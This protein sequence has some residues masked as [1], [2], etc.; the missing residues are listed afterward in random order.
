MS[1]KP[2]RC[3][4][5]PHYS[6]LYLTIAAVGIFQAAS[7][8]DYSSQ[9]RVQR[10]LAAA[11]PRDTRCCICPLEEPAFEWWG[12]WSLRRPPALGDIGVGTPNG[13]Q[14]PTSSRPTAALG[15][16]RTSRAS[17]STHRGAPVAPGQRTRDFSLPDFFGSGDFLG[18]ASVPSC[19][20]RCSLLRRRRGARPAR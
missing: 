11:A 18:G 16:R 12:V 7:K 4:T 9:I 10:H 1:R 19:P 20:R 6:L 14:P 15:P 8:R 3:G 13:L 2:Y 17:W 5:G